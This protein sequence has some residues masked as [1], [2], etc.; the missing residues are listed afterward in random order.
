MCS[1]RQQRSRVLLGSIAVIGSIV[2]LGMGVL[3][4]EATHGNLTCMATEKQQ[5]RAM[6]AGTREHHAVCSQ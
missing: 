3:L 5:S 2:A 4:L 6:F 1:E